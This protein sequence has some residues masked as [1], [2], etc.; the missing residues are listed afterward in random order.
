MQKGG[1]IPAWLSQKQTT[2][3]C[4]SLGCNNGFGGNGGFSPLTWE[5][6]KISPVPAVRSCVLGLWHVWEGGAVAQ[7]V[8]PGGH[9]GRVSGQDTGRGET[10]GS[11]RVL[12]QEPF[13]RGVYGGPLDAVGNSP[14]WDV[15]W[16]PRRAG[17]WGQTQAFLPILPTLP[18][19]L[20]WE[21]TF[22]PGSA[23]CWGAGAEEMLGPGLGACWGRTQLRRPICPMPHCMGA[24]VQGDLWSL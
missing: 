19:L 23:H 22:T 10:C 4:S 7:G 15:G 6:G 18:L 8:D 1:G 9:H 11:H 20:S 17:C 2:A 21:G 16:G 14:W 3:S 12:S 5:L 24:I 13:Q